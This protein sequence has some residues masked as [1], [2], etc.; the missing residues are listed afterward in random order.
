MVAHVFMDAERNWIC[1]QKLTL[2]SQD[3]SQC[4]SVYVCVCVCVCVCAPRLLVVKVCV[5]V[6]MCQWVGLCNEASASLHMSDAGLQFPRKISIRNLIS[7][8][9]CV[10]FAVCFPLSASV[11]PRVHFPSQWRAALTR[12]MLRW[13][14]EDGTPG[15]ENGWSGTN[16][17]VSLCVSLIPVVFFSLVL[18]EKVDL[19]ALRA[20]VLWLS[21]GKCC[22]CLGEN[23]KGEGGIH[24]AETCLTRSSFCV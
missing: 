7:S 11:F 18:L 1:D 9:R 15:S 21:R 19:Y 2:W 24:S 10:A 23:W 12:W 3:C 13:K 22:D 6:H 8:L 16:W 5:R 4:V 17:S 14:V 20:A